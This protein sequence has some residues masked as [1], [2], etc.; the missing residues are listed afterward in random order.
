[1]D[2]AKANRPPVIGEPVCMGDAG[3]VGAG[4]RPVQGFLQRAPVSRGAG[5]R[6]AGWRVL[7]ETRVNPDAAGEIEGRNAGPAQS[8]EHKTAGAGGKNRTL[9]QVITIF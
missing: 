9:A 8:G 1:M 3:G 7:R 4:G 6:D 2:R 5:K